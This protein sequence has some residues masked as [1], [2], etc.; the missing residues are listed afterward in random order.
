MNSEAIKNLLEGIQSLSY[1]Q[2]KMLKVNVDT[3]FNAKIKD[4][5]V[6]FDEEVMN[7]ICE[8]L[9]NNG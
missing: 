2:W 6:H 1:R 4:A 7:L 5:K 3:A 9:I 8:D